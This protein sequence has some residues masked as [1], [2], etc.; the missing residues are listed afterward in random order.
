MR[1]SKST[2]DHFTNSKCQQ[3]QVNSLTPL[4]NVINY[5]A[6]EKINAKTKCFI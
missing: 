4:L 6:A 1:Y 5:A 2:G 3:Q